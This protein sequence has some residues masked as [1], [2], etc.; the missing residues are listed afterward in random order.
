[1]GVNKVLAIGN[2]GRDPELKY[3]PVGQPVC[4]F[5][6]AVSEKWTDKSGQKQEKTEWLNIVVWGKMGENASKY[7]S[8]GRPVFIEGKISTRTWD[9]K[10]GTKRY[11]TE[12]VASNVQ[13]L[14]G[15]SHEEGQTTDS[16]PIPPEEDL[17]F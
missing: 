2:L 3:T 4:T 9:D 5:S 13:F 17:P 16:M 14:G 11:R 15:G 12:I 1:M 10:D 8:K 6:I 7:L